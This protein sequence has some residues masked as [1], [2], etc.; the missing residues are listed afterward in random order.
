MKKR[1][2]CL[3]KEARYWALRT[4]P[5]KMIY[6]LTKTRIPPLFIWISY[7]TCMG[8]NE[9]MHFCARDLVDTMFKYDFGFLMLLCFLNFYPCRYLESSAYVQHILKCTQ[10]EEFPVGY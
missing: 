10:T 4:R 7:V 1:L 2:A 8:I 3:S 6:K 5:L 9:Q